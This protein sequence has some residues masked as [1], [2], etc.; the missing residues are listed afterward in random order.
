MQLV[1][2]IPQNYLKFAQAQ[3]NRV[4]CSGPIRHRTELIRLGVLD[5]KH[6]IAKL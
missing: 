2:N 4:R 6:S 1:T 5:T 3:W